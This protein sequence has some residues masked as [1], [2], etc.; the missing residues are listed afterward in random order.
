MKTVGPPYSGKLNV[1]WDEKGM[2]GRSAMAPSHF[3]T[4]DA[5]E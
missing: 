4:L 1:R 2:I 5:V 3:F